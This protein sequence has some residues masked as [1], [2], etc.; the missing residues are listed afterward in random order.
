MRRSGTRLLLT[1]NGHTASDLLDRIVRHLKTVLT[2]TERKDDPQ[3][4]AFCEIISLLEDDADGIGSERWK[5]PE[6]ISHWYCAFNNLLFDGSL[7]RHATLEIEQEHLSME[8]RVCWTSGTNYSHRVLNRI[9]KRADLAGDM[10]KQRQE[11]LK[12]LIL[13]QMCHVVFHRYACSGTLCELSVMPMDG[14]NTID[15]IAAQE[16]LVRMVHEQIGQNSMLAEALGLDFQTDAD[17][18][19]E[20]EADS[21]LPWDDTWFKD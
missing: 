17:D 15:H 12:D 8:L 13:H 3:L 20:D 2:H 18:T 19:S 14:E 11:I 10:I 5:D 6:Y 1:L 4:V 16:L 7:L 9:D 21:E